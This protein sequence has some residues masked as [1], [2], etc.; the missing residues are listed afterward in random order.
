[1]SKLVSWVNFFSSFRTYFILK[2]STFFFFYHFSE[3]NYNVF[4]YIYLRNSSHYYYHC[5]KKVAIL[6]VGNG[7]AAQPCQNGNIP[8][9]FFP[10]TS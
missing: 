3:K 7:W 8:P 6:I 5:E 10:K 9:P 1:M 2:I 4:L